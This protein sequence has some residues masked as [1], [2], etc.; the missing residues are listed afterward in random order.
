ME[1]NKPDLGPQ[2]S[3]P[4]SISTFAASSIGKR[5]VLLLIQKKIHKIL[6]HGTGLMSTDEPE[7]LRLSLGLCIVFNLICCGR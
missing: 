3:W 2:F 4:T 1:K 5:K 7:T 6:L